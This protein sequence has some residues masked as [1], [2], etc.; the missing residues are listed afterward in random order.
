VFGGDE[1]VGGAADDR[2][3]TGVYNI[4][5]GLGGSRKGEYLLQNAA[6]RRFGG[7]WRPIHGDQAHRRG[8]FC[9]GRYQAQ[10]DQGVRRWI[11]QVSWD[12]DADRRGNGN[13]NDPH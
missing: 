13:R 9:H 10:G 1:Q 6:Q 7:A 2:S 5:Q 12:H 3:G 11:E 8:A 4:E